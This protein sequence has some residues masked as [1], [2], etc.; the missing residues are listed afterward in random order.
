MAKNKLH[1]IEIHP[2]DNG[3]TVESHFERVSKGKSNAF[4]EMPPVEKHVFGN[5]EHEKMLNHISSV[6]NVKHEGKVEP[7]AQ[8]TEE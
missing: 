6:L 3:H 4:Y 8:D 5:D 1:H 2:A 7:A